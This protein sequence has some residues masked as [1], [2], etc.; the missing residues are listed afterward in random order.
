[1]AKKQAF[2]LT[3]YDAREIIKTGELTSE[4][5]MERAVRAKR[6]L[7]LMNNDQPGLEPLIMA[8]S[9]LIVDYE[10]KHWSNVNLITDDQMSESVLAE[11]QVDK[12]GSFF[13]KR[14]E[15]I[16]QKLKQHALNQNDLSA[17]L[18]HSKSYTSELLN[19]V[20]TFSLSDLIIIHKLFDISLE[21]LILTEIPV[22][23]KKKFNE[24]KKESAR[25][26]TKNS[27]KVRSGKVAVAQS[28]VTIRR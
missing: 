5:E 21:N 18:S 2:A 7:R 15:L 16:T 12:E 6:L 28:L 26:K 3:A 24:A 1:M 27:S 4:L 19:G 8:L 9:D 25:R 14:K 17:I 22:E 13:R 23:I 20:R 11:K 10:S